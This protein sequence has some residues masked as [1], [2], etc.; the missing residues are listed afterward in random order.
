M[1]DDLIDERKSKGFKFTGVTSE[2]YHMPVPLLFRPQFGANA[3]SASVICN[4]M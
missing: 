4:P 1:E 2:F 3:I